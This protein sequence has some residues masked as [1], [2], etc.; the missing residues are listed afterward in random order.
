MCP[1]LLKT[2]SWSL[3]MKLSC[4]SLVNHTFKTTQTIRVRFVGDMYA[5]CWCQNGVPYKYIQY[6]AI[7]L[8]CYINTSLTCTVIYSCY[9]GWVGRW[10]VLY[11]FGFCC[12]VFLNHT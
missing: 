11:L 1:I 8:S 7:S 2:A 6:R 12:C 3:K 10:V 5:R 9:E 4:D